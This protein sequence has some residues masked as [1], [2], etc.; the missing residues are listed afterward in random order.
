MH[1]IDEDRKRHLLSADQR[2]FKK[3]LY[4]LINK[5]PMLS[6][7]YISFGENGS[8]S[9]DAT[10]E[11]LMF[12]NSLKTWLGYTLD[13]RHLITA[14][15]FEERF[16][17]KPITELIKLEMIDAFKSIE[18]YCVKLDFQKADFLLKQVATT[19]RENYGATGD[20]YFYLLVDEKIEVFK[21][22]LEDVEKNEHAS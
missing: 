17:F 5:R 1:L 15:T 2:E 7:N 3:G 18:K 14:Y 20:L 13:Y 4:R 21:Y 22:T 6:P 8:Y 12:S 9:N 10:F 16:S 11:S 19:F